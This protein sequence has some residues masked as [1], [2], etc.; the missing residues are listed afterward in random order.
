MIRQGIKQY[1]QAQ[2]DSR[3]VHGE[4]LVGKIMQKATIFG[5]TFLQNKALVT[6]L[7]EMPCA[8]EVADEK[9]LQSLVHLVEKSI[10]CEKKACMSKE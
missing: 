3:A 1:Q 9:L 6:S 5:Y 2:Y 4:K 7:C 8:G 10:E